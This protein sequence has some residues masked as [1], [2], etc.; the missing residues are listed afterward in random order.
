MPIEPTEDAWSSDTSS[1]DDLVDVLADD[2]HEDSL[3]LQEEDA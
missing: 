3:L 2:D 1:E